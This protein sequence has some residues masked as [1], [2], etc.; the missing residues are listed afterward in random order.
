MARKPS[1]TLTD[2]ELR[3]MRVLWRQGPSTVAAIVDAVAG[4][5]SPAYNTVQTMMRILE[6]KGFVT[7]RKDGRAFVFDALVDESRAQ[8]SA[9]RHVLDRFFDN[10]PGTMVLS[11]LEHEDVPNAE[12][13][14]LR[15]LIERHEWR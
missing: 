15:E 5:N 8:K 9:I 13:R 3:L 6:R 2:G 7:H 4:A 14:Q 12:L 10:S 1:P 11:L